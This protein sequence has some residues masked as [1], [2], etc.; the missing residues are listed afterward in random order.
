VAALDPEAQ[1]EIGID[2]N[3]HTTVIVVERD[4]Y[5]PISSGEHLG[6][7]VQLGAAELQNFLGLADYRFRY[8]PPLA[9]TPA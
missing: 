9:I 2:G 8:R 7:E 3:L 6:T 5:V 1:R 4:R